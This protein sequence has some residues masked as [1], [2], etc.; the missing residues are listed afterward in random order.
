MC[1]SGRGEGTVI[2]KIKTLAVGLLA[3][4]A[5]LASAG[6]IQLVKDINRHVSA[7]NFFSAAQLGNGWVL[8]QTMQWG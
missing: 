5:T 6:Q 7:S 4:L 2:N 3:C 8:P 1:R